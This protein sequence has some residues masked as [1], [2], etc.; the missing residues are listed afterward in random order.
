MK[1]IAL[2][3]LLL[4]SFKYVNAQNNLGFHFYIP[5]SNTF[6]GTDKPF[7]YHGN[8]QMSMN[9]ELFYER[10]TKKRIHHFGLSYQG[11]TFK[12][13]DSSVQKYMSEDFTT[14]N[15]TLFNKGKIGNVDIYSGS[16]ALISVLH[17]QKRYRLNSTNLVNESSFGDLIKFSLFVETK[18]ILPHFSNE[19]NKIKQALNF[20]IG[21]DLGGIKRNEAVLN[22][23]MFMSAGYSLFYP[24]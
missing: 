23:L 21:L 19:H 1:K 11:N 10:E 14:L 12:Y 8:T 4:I 22:N 6:Q 17:N 5:I 9:L 3:V 18:V 24:F 16:G 13:L 15:Y 2:I 7:D 20:R